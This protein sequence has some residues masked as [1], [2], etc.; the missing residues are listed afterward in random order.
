MNHTVPSKG[1]CFFMAVTPFLE[2]VHSFF[3]IFNSRVPGTINPVIA[4]KSFFKK[5]VTSFKET[6]SRF[7]ALLI[8]FLAELCNCCNHVTLL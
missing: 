3:D 7:G 1:T 6:G 5:K 8:G 4:Q 2:K